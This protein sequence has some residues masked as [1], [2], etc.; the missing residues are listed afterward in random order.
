MFT[1]EEI[2]ELHE[3][4]KRE[5]GIKISVDQAALYGD[6]LIALIRSVY[7]KRVENG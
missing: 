4:F 1:S 3:L 2:K 6:Q 5:L 7:E